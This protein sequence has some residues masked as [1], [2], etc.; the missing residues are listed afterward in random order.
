MNKVSITLFM[1]EISELFCMSIRYLVIE[2]KE[3]KIVRLVSDW[4]RLAESTGS[5]S[6]GIVITQY[7][8]LKKTGITEVVNFSKNNPQIKLLV[9][10]QPSEFHYAASLFQLGVHGFFSDRITKEE[11]D[12]CLKELAE[13]RTYFSQDV[14]AGLLNKENKIDYH[15]FP[16]ISG[17]E[18][19]ILDMIV[20]GMTNKEIAGKM[21][22]SI[23]TI[24]GHRARLI[25]KFGVRNTAEM[26]SEATRSRELSR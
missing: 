18:E 26:V 17:R 8:W 19:E 7:A 1:T 3:V 16:A 24:E 14:I 11:F 10:L 22:L 13:S 5:E 15:P 12:N 4:E 6:T 25:S 2:N 23:R 21:C 20:K 9:Y